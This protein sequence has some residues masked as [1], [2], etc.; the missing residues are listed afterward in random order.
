MNPSQ[1]LPTYQAAA[2]AGEE[3]AGRAARRMPHAPGN[4]I[5]YQPRLVPARRIHR[6][7]RN[8]LQPVY[9][10]Y[11][12]PVATPRDRRDRRRTALALRQ[13]EA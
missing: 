12:R 7:R 11:R 1:P 10:A 8:K 3:D 6:T 2:Q 9:L 13:A 5:R 4:T